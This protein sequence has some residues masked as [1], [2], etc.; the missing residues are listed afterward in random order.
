M[1]TLAPGEERSAAASG[2]GGELRG[3][4]GILGRAP[5]RM[6]LLACTVSGRQMEDS[7]LTKN[8]TLGGLSELLKQQTRKES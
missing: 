1:V 8:Q 3:V 2:G 6:L 4:I 7:D 5:Q